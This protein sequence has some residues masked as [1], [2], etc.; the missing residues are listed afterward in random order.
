MVTVN[1]AKK[2]FAL[3]LR[4]VGFIFLAT[5]VVTSAVTAA[6]ADTVKA[7][8]VRTIDTSRWSPPSPDPMGITVL[9]NGHLLVSDSE[10]EECVNSNPP[11]YWHGVNLF[12]ADR[13]GTLLATAT[14]YT[15][16]PGSCI[17]FFGPGPSFTSEPTG[18]AINP[19]NGH[20]FFSD[21][22]KK[23]I[24]EV[25]LGP[26]GKYGTADDTVTSFSTTAVNALIDPEGIAFGPGGDLFLA[27]GGDH[28][29]A[30]VYQIAP[31][32]NGRFD[33]VAPTG[34]D[35]VVGHF[36]TVS[37]GVLDPEGVA[38]NPDSG[39]LYII[40]TD[41]HLVE[42]TTTGA[43]VR[44]IDISALPV[45]EPSDVIYAP[46]SLV[47]VVKHLYITDRG[48]DNNADPF[49]NDGK[50]YEITVNPIECILPPPL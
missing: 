2:P 16:P 49:E 13:S 24:F 37:L 35:R 22:D 36:D 40:G 7:C 33:G 9:P 29:G 31:G 19:T 6:H 28:G 25:D 45:V 17:P 12:E 20:L 23:R 8:L 42:V 4:V 48:V 11:V 30:A 47:P 50:I 5:V 15:P 43:L 1:Q 46:G 10:V 44:T 26:D 34:D 18:I 21:D 27:S 14:T 32:L 39:T 41:R 38:F 3:L